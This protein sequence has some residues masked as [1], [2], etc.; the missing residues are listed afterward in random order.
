MAGAGTASGGLDSA[1]QGGAVETAGAA[2]H[3]GVTGH[4]GAAGQSG[5]CLALEPSFTQ[6]TP[7]VFIL[8]DRQ[9]AMFAVDPVAQ[10]TPW[11]AVKTGMLK[12]ITELQYTTR[13]GVGAFTG[14]AGGT[15][16][17][18]TSVPPANANANAITSFYET[19]GAVAGKTETPTSAALKVAEQV[20][21]AD[22]SEGTKNILL[23]SNG[24]PDF[25]DDG[26]PICALDAT[27]ARV[28]KLAAEGITTAMLD[29]SNALSDASLKAIANAGAGQPAAI[30]FGPT[31]A[32]LTC[33]D[34]SGYPGWDAEWTSAS[35]A[36]DCATSG[37]QV[38]GTY[39]PVGGSTPTYRSD[40]SDQAALN[41][42]IAAILSSF[43][44]CSFDLGSPGSLDPT[45][46]G[47]AVI[48]ID[49][50]PVPMSTSN[51]WHLTSPTQLALVG[52]ACADWRKPTTKAI[53]F[54]F[55]CDALR[56]P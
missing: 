11:A 47:S 3:A 55:P 52:S 7:T 17:L 14:Q 25:C 19:I 43:K 41:A 42:Q 13:F 23:V 48:R 22:V 24:Q 26:N 28:Q 2:G 50:Q 36:R 29:L 4:G 31:T 51:G 32:Q 15:C 49:A 56:V 38:L 39:S 20:L 10:V 35:S 6:K 44:S 53:T 9:S 46:A 16:P 37:K 1:G 34:C 54:E 30:P 40:L 5:G 8:L 21:T 27:V 18:F 45:A 12:A 33:Y